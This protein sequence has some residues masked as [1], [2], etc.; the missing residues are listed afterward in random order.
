MKELSISPRLEKGGGEV[1]SLYS[2]K[3]SLDNSKINDMELYL[4]QWGFEEIDAN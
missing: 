4:S 1:S 2:E 3:L